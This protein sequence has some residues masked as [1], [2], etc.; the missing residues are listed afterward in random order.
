MAWSSLGWRRRGWAPGA[1]YHAT[2]QL[3]LMMVI[4]M[5]MFITMMEE[6]RWAPGA[7]YHATPRLGHHQD[8]DNH[9]HGAR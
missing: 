9:K 6:E 3:G 5:M 8:G 7:L 4:M 1:Q 2:P